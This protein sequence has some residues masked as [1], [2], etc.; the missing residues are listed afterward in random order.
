MGRVENQTDLTNRIWENWLECD[1]KGERSQSLIYKELKEQS[2]RK[3]LE[4]SENIEE[5]IQKAEE[6][7]FGTYSG[8]ED[9]SGKKLKRAGLYQ[10]LQAVRFAY[11]DG[12][13]SAGNALNLLKRSIL[14][15]KKAGERLR[16][17]TDEISKL[18]PE[19]TDSYAENLF[20]GKNPVLSEY[21]YKLV[22]ALVSNYFKQSSLPLTRKDIPKNEG[23]TGEDYYLN[24][25]REKSRIPERE[26]A[27]RISRENAGAGQNDGKKPVYK[28]VVGLMNLYNES[29][30][31]S[32][33]RG[34]TGKV[35]RNEKMT[36][37]D[38][39]VDFSET[40]R[41]KEFQNRCD[42]LFRLLNEKVPEKQA[43]NVFIRL[44]ISS[45]TGCGIFIIG[46][47]RLSKELWNWFCEDCGSREYR[48]C[49]AVLSFQEF[50]S[51][52]DSITFGMNPEFFTDFASARKY[53]DIIAHD[54][55]SLFE[56]SSE[57]ELEA[58]LPEYLQFF[59]HHEL[60][61]PMSSY[62]EK[63]IQEYIKKEEEKKKREREKKSK[64]G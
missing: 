38:L 35:R 15:D 16:K 1:E 19:E 57:A 10:L 9:I 40:N 11:R 47:E 53:M 12:R 5:Y 54:V 50:D 31:N 22:I 8:K 27:R 23:N 33:D 26:E 56:D 2:D 34:N 32:A 37:G 55:Y 49:I 43:V 61:N 63:I 39:T 6:K 41:E 52:E 18:K 14:S 59:I 64:K 51:Y 30:G 25:Y 24:L 60:Q 46:K 20:S 36:G 45:G 29:L 7:A 58:Y 62:E 28:D 44:M 42:E 21:Q 17:L 48:C 4:I 13:I 3:A